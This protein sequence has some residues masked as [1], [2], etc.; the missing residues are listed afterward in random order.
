MNYYKLLK[1]LPPDFLPELTIRKPSQFAHRRIDK[2]V[3]AKLA[4]SQS[5]QP[6][7]IFERT[8]RPLLTSLCTLAFVAVLAAAIFLV[9]TATDLTGD[10]ITL[11]TVQ[12]TE[13]DTSSISATD[14]DVTLT[15][16]DAKLDGGA[17]V[18]HLKLDC[19]NYS[20]SFLLG[21]E[22]ALTV[23]DKRVWQYYVPMEHAWSGLIAGDI[24]GAFGE[25]DGIEFKINTGEIK[26]G[27]NSRSAKLTIGSLYVTTENDD[28]NSASVE[29]LCENLELEFDF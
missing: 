16:I 3:R 24:L 26:D 15:L 1:N 6:S 27:V 4:G 5:R 29:L 28:H 21:E 20:G 22:L 23:G 19:G 18:L 25:A 10:E 14:G 8:S 7:H 11:A 9:R 17:L 2:L 12:P 13:P